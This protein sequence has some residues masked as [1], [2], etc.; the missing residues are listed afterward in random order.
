MSET[1]SEFAIATE[2]RGRI[3]ILTLDRPEK[4]NSFTPVGYASMAEVLATAAADDGVAVCVLTGRGRAFSAGV[5]LSVM[6]RPGGAAEL[7]R[8]F[9][10]MLDQLARFPKPLI[11]A[12]NG[13][14]VGLGATILLHCDLVVV[15]EGAEIR[16]PFVSLGTSAE[17]ASSWLLPRRVG[18][19]QASWM[20]LSGRGLNA[21]EAVANGFAF[22]AA[23]AGQALDDAL[24]LAEQMAAHETR[25]L[26]VNKRLIRQGWAEAIEQAWSRER[27]AMLELAEQVG[28]IGWKADG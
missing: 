27:A 18:M 1:P 13:L 12:V 28:P 14:A 21:S 10:P 11:A 24:V 6:G 7:G 8:H 22:A 15:D 26:M 5:D 2:D 17:A 23:A 19:Q 3:R 20:I 16:M 9:D 4:L 25:A